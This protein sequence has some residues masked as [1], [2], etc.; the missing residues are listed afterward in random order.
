MWCASCGAW[1]DGGGSTPLVAE[2]SGISPLSGTKRFAHE[3]EAITGPVPFA[4]TRRSRRPVAVRDP[5]IWSI[6]LAELAE[7]ADRPEPTAPDDI[8][9][10][11][12]TAAAE[13]TVVSAIILPPPPPS[14]TTVPED[15]DSDDTDS[16]GGADD[17]GDMGADGGTQVS[18]PAGSLTPPSESTQPDRGPDVN[19]AIVTAMRSTKPGD[20]V[21]SSG[22]TPVVDSARPVRID[23]TPLPH[24]EPSSSMLR[25]VHRRR[26]GFSGQVIDVYGTSLVG[27]FDQLTG[28]VD[29]DLTPLPDAGLVSRRH[30]VL[31]RR[32]D[33]WEVRDAGSVNGVFV[34][35]RGA[36]RFGAR[37]S[38]PAPIQDGDEIAFGNVHF[39]VRI[40]SI[41]D[42]IGKGL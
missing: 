33:N 6:R 27:R 36:E 34:R 26:G 24:V 30:A 16:H 22:A 13:A 11:A 32:G 42:P 4:P 2:S 1:I 29:V 31:E 15:H 37:L 39:M 5:R 25:L 8:A 18:R 28:P 38:R 14:E 20:L 12:R 3:E 19:P 23:G 10:P 17:T 21:V 9:A 35:T 40:V 41:A 7:Q